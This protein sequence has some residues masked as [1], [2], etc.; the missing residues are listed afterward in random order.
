VPTAGVRRL[1]A[2]N[3]LNGVLPVILRTTDVITV[4][5]SL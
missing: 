1:I 2:L 4:P 3:R 5:D